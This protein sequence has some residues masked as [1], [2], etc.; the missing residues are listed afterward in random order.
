MEVTAVSRMVTLAS[1]SS[2]RM[3]SVGSMEEGGT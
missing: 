3:G 2:V 1:L